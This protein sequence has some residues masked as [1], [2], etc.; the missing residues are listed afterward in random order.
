MCVCMSTNEMFYK[1]EGEKEGRKGREGGKQRERRREGEG[2]KEG[3][4][5]RN[6]LLCV[7]TLYVHNA[8]CH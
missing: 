3:G 6:G 1:Q 4:R 8:T 2:E 7:C 5:G